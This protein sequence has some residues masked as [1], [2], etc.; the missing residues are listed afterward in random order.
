L[1]VDASG[2][3]GVGV[4]PSASLEV[5]GESRFS[6]S[7]ASTQYV[8]IIADGTDTRIVAEGSSKNLLI[9]N[10]STTSSAIFFD[11]AVASVY[12]FQ[13]AG[14]ERFRIRAD[15]TFE[16]KGGG[17]AGMSP[18]VSVNPSAS[19][20]S[21]VID[22]SGRLGIG[23]TSPAYPVHLASAVSGGGDIGYRV[24]DTT[25]NKIVQL[26]RT[27]STYSYIGIGATEGVVYSDTTLSL[28]AD[29]SNPIKFC[30]GGGEAVRIDSSKRLLV[31]T[32]NAPAGAPAGSVTAKG[33]VYLQSPNGT[34]FAV[35][36]SDAGQLSVTQVALTKH[37]VSGQD[38]DKTR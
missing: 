38:S 5:N 12:V 24:Q 4:S 14:T 9:K 15:G 36:V 30:A 10:N 29:N 16:I 26:H 33:G 2:N 35:G 31:G 23:T 1:F 32:V 13:Q 22:A 17:T 11:Q 19:A 3:V 28:A 25:N 18:A 37:D 8:G 20:N 27:G 21:L 7:G 34:W 6:R